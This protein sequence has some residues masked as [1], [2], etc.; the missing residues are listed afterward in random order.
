M[1]ERT[2]DLT[3]RL[4]GKSAARAKALVASTTAMPPPNT[5]IFPI[6]CPIT[7]IYL[8]SRQLSNDGFGAIWLRLQVSDSAPLSIGHSVPPFARTPPRTI[9][10]APVET[11]A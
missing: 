7:L 10:K 5:R 3:G 1:T 11:G 6:A 8:K 2:G 4:G 9:K